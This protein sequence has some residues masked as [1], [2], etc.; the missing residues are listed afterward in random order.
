MVQKRIYHSDRQATPAER[1]RALRARKRNPLSNAPPAVVPGGAAQAVAGPPP[2]AAAPKRVRSRG[3]LAPRGFEE[4][5]KRGAVSPLP[6]ADHRKLVHLI[7]AELAS[8]LK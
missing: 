2:P 8:G 3:A 6:S 5:A 4:N 7:D 1:M